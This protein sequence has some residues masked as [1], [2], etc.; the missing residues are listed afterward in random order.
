MTIQ[1]MNSANRTSSFLALLVLLALTTIIYF[2]GLSGDYMFDDRPNLL[3]NDRLDIE[4]LD[5]ES[6]ASASLSSGS[7]MLRRPVSMLSFALNRH[8]FGFAPYSYKVINLVIH[9]LTGVML[10]LFTRLLVRALQRH[11]PNLSA[12][13]RLWLPLVVSGLWLVHPLNLSSV[14]YIIQRMTSLSTLFMVCGLCLYA[15]GRLRLLEGKRGWPI[16]LAGFLGFGG[17]AIFSKESGALLPLYLLVLELTLFRFRDQHGRPD[18]AIL[19]F[20]AV[21]LLVPGLFVLTWVF[22]HPEFILNGYTKREFNLTERLLTEARI[23]VF[24]LQMTVMP[25]INSL[26]LYHDDITISKGLL[27]PPATLGALLFLFSLLT[28]ALVFIKKLPLFSLGI[29]WFFC[30]H[31]MESTAIALELAHEHRN[32]LADFGI[33]LALAGLATRFTTRDLRPLVTIVL[34][35]LFMALFSWTTWIRAGQWSDNISHAIY[36]A[37]HHPQS[38]RA[39]YSAGRIHARLALENVPGAYEKANKYLEDA[40]SIGG[41]DVMSS[42]VL[43]KLGY[44]THHPV[45]PAWSR[46]ILERLPKY[47]ITP[48]TV[49]SLY[50][51]SSCMNGSCTFPHETMEEMFRLTLNNRSLLSNKRLYAEA[52]SVYGFFTINVREDPSK[53]LELFYGAAELEPQNPQRHINL[54]NLLTAMKRYDEAGQRLEIFMSTETHGGNVNDYQELKAKIDAAREAE[55]PNT[56]GAPQNNE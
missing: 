21:F 25:S 19:G 28:S 12:T 10:F 5:L 43:I 27:A 7:G 49:N 46:T 16:I 51:L 50:E 42:I 2:P 9:L 40:R 54:V 23:L 14:L 39:V 24:Y 36:E 35:V 20:F 29:L 22:N 31:V 41:S 8:F 53:G 47:P 18:K 56:T 26:G 33:I 3:Q 13:T 15:A 37:E 4:S 55:T 48:T 1:L 44:L 52:K 32:Y 45:D 38:L 11:Q 30:G 17:L 34:P 6:L